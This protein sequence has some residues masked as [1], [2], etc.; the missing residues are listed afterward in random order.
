MPVHLRYTPLNTPPTFF[1]AD[2][3]AYVSGVAMN[4]MSN[5]NNTPQCTQPLAYCT[6]PFTDTL[7]SNYSNFYQD[8]SNNNINV[9][10]TTTQTVLR[11]IT[12]FSNY[13]DFLYSHTVDSADELPIPLS[14]TINHVYFQRRED[15]AVLGVTTRYCNKF[16]TVVYYTHLPRTYVA[17]TSTAVMA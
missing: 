2:K 14:V 3:P 1:R 12:E 5:L 17:T 10:D 15:H 11:P 13:N 8:T 4:S 16:T 6:G 9:N 7:S